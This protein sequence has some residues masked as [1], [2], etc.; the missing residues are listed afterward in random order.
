M[1]YAAIARPQVLCEN[2]RARSPRTEKGAGRSEHGRD[3]PVKSLRRLC[4]AI[5]ALDQR[6]GQLVHWAVPIAVLVSAGNAVSRH[7]MN[8]AS[9][10][11]LELQ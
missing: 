10:A 11:R 4:R 9:N 5:D 8:V 3:L 6:V 7:T 2:S 1:W